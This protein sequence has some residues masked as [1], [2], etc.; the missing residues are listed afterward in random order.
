[1]RQFTIVRHLHNVTKVRNAQAQYGPSSTGLKG[2][3][4]EIHQNSKWGI[5]PTPGCCPYLAP[6]SLGYI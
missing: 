6:L 5:Q 4:Q 1:M 2:Q 3:M